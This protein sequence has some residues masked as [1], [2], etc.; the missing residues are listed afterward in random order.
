MLCQVVEVLPR[1]A[2]IRNVIIPAVVGH[3]LR[4]QKAFHSLL[5]VLKDR[6]DLV[7]KRLHRWIRRACLRAREVNEANDDYDGYQIDIETACGLAFTAT[8]KRKRTTK[9]LNLKPPKKFSSDGAALM[10]EIG[11]RFYNKSVGGTIVRP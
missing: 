8:G 7:T 11:L 3:F 5:T 4:V 10:L 9:R 2:V 6:L 1:N